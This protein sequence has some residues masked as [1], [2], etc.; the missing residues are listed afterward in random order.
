[1]PFHIETFCISTGRPSRSTV[2][3][4]FQ[5]DACRARSRAASSGSVAQRPVSSPL[6]LVNTHSRSPTTAV[7]ASFQLE[8]RRTATGDPSRRTGSSPLRVAGRAGL[9][10][11]EHCV[12]PQPIPGA[13]ATLS[14]V[15]RYSR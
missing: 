11:F 12:P 8:A 4:P 13:P 7:A 15:A 9:A 3:V 2:Q 6:R 1:M 5:N 14:P 10:E